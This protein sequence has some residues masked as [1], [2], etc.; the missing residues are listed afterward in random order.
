MN[1]WDADSRFKIGVFH[2][3]RGEPEQAAE[4]LLQA[5]QLNRDNENYRSVA[6]DAMQR[7]AE[8]RPNDPRLQE[9]AAR[10][11]RP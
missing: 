5:M 9:M 6:R 10:Y 3:W 4:P 2:L 7:W 8:S 11:G 1:P